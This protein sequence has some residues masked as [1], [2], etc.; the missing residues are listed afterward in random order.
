MFRSYV[1]KYVNITF[2]L[3]EDHK[4]VEKQRNQ[5]VTIN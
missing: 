4:T 5:K 3:N 2:H 1:E